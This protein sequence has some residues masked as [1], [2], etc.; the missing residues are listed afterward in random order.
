MDALLNLGATQFASMEGASPLLISLQYKHPMIA[1]RLLALDQKEP[2]IDAQTPRDGVFPLH[3]AAGS[4]Y[5]DVVKVL[6]KRGANIHQK[7]RLGDTAISNAVRTG[8]TKIAKM[9]AK[10]AS[11]AEC[12]FS[13]YLSAH[14]GNLEILELLLSAI[15]QRDASGN[16]TKS[17]MEDTI[18][19][20]M[21]PDEATLLFAA[22]AQGHTS[23]VDYL[24]RKGAKTDP[25]IL[26]TK[27]TPLLAAAKNGHYDV[28]RA[29]LSY[30]SNA[31]AAGNKRIHGATPL[32][33]AAQ[34]GHFTICKLLID[35]GKAHVNTR[36][37]KLAVTPLFLAAELGNVKIVQLLL[38]KGAHV[39]TRNE[40]GLS[41]FHG[42]ISAGSGTEV[43]R[44]LKKHGANI[45]SRDN[46]NSTPLLTALRGCKIRETDY[47]LKNGADPNALVTKVDGS[48]VSGL[49]AAASMSTCSR[50]PLTAAVKMA[51]MLLEFGANPNLG[52][53]CPLAVAV[54]TQNAD[55][56]RLLCL[57][58]SKLPSAL[59]PSD[60]VS[61]DPLGFAVELECVECVQIILRAFPEKASSRWDLLEKSK[62][63]R[64]F[65]LIKAF[66]S[67]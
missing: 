54:A 17:K 56:I 42:A 25:K 19:R 37:R 6:L 39:G 32:H 35:H 8:K 57:K 11:K 21:G 49:V 16:I 13:A 47:L 59:L 28:V 62:S 44:L 61:N 27:S 60:R 14:T 15:R 66:S 41:P 30:G 63:K 67:P 55:L 10:D 34:N 20:A 65:D 2:H 48:V 5:G 58:G 51:N 4:G 33:V 29:L 1:L 45:N 53:P 23:A 50:E 38:A 64:N 43:Y 36:L 22:S 12:V 31:N 9:L 40:K 26:S 24:L 46:S 3:V 7:T 52:N 18:N